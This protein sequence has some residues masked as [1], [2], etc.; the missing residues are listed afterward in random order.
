MLGDS[1]RLTVEYEDRYS[2]ETQVLTVEKPSFLLARMRDGSS[3]ESSDSVPEE[4]DLSAE[5]ARGLLAG[6]GIDLEGFQEFRDEPID[7]F[8]GL[9]FGLAENSRWSAE[10]M[11]EYKVNTWD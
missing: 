4:T 8:T 3:F 11:G 5:E 6:N 9:H 1:A 10:S 2:L 7:F